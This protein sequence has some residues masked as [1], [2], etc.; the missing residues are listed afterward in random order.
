MSTLHP[1]KA[2]LLDTAV[3]LIDEF[4]PIGFTV[5]ALLE[6]STISKGSLYHHFVDFSDVIE[7]AQVIR[8]SRYIDADIKALFEMLSTARSG[9]ELRERFESLVLATSDPSR[10]DARS[11]RATIVGLARHSKNF[12]EALGREQQRVTD[13]LADIARE[14]QEKGYIRTDVDVRVLAT[15]IQTYTLGF[16]L[17]DITIDPILPDEWSKF[18]SA[19][20]AASL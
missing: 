3:A 20:L 6:R 10:A 14:A 13:A 12:A 9:A 7:Q 15:F 2:K 4:G 19:L 17:N 11:D 8:F 1:T 16:V 5:D 18:V